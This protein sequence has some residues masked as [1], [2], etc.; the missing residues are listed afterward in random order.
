MILKA[1]GINPLIQIIYNSDNKSTIKHGTW[2]LSNL[3]RGKPLPEYELVKDALPVLAKVLLTQDDPE[4]ITD[5]T[6]ALS[7]LSG[8]QKYL[9]LYSIQFRFFLFCKKKF[10]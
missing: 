3:C 9:F 8:N 1:G 5:A 2:A 7:Y 10:C 6:W 4:V